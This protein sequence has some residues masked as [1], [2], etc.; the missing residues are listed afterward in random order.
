MPFRLLRVTC[1]RR[2]AA[3]GL[4]FRADP[5]KHTV[6]PPYRLPPAPG[7][8]LVWCLVRMERVVKPHSEFQA[9]TG[10]TIPIEEP[11]VQMLEVFSNGCDAVSLSNLLQYLGESFP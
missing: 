6:H 8:Q 3:A 5:R 1:R 11:D 7:Y 9:A 10:L 2:T 4:A